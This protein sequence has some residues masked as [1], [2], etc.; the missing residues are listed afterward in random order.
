[1]TKAMNFKYP[2]EEEFDQREAQSGQV[3]QGEYST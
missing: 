3:V 2:S 1:M